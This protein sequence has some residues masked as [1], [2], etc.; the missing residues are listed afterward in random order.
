MLEQDI[1]IPADM[2]N[3]LIDFLSNFINFAYT[4]NAMSIKN[5]DKAKLLR[6][7]YKNLNFEEGIA[8][9]NK[10]EELYNECVDDLEYYELY[11]KTLKD[12]LY[13][14]KPMFLTMLHNENY[15]NGGHKFR[16]ELFNGEMKDLAKV[17]TEEEW[18]ETFIDSYINHPLEYI[19]TDSRDLNYGEYIFNGYKF[20]DWIT[21]DYMEI[22]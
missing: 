17:R 16:F 20:P 11:W 6:E 5:D 15:G 9:A 1:Y 19:G 7:A 14:F 22:D 4:N 13:K 3:P 21:E 10:Y 12:L 2:N 18:I 8:F